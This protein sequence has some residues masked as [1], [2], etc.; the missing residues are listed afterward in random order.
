MADGPPQLI[1]LQIDEAALAR[2][3][4]EAKQQA[5]LRFASEV[6]NFAREEAPE[7]RGYM[8][9]KIK[10]YLVPGGAIVVV[11]TDYAIFVHEGTGIYAVDSRAG[12]TPWTYFKDGRYYTTYGQRPNRFL[13]RALDRASAAR[14]GVS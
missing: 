2:I 9:G 1:G 11:D 13:T 12:K 6:A 4:E 10:V 3:G 5:S 8:K 14:E 7:E